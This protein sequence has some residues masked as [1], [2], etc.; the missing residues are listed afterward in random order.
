MNEVKSL[1][2]LLIL[3]TSSYY[4]LQ[5]SFMILPLG[6]GVSRFTVEWVEGGWAITANN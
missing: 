5:T 4:P 2:L 6:G 1:P 3:G